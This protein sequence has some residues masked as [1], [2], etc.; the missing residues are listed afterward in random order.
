MRTKSQKK[1][2]VRDEKPTGMSPNM[3]TPPKPKKRKKPNPYRAPNTV[4]RYYAGIGYGVHLLRDDLLNRLEQDGLL[5]DELSHLIRERSRA[6]V[7]SSA[8]KL[9]ELERQKTKQKMKEWE[10]KEWESI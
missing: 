6:L 8:K 1:M 3:A 9:A 10:E 5:T 2:R 7:A 4:K